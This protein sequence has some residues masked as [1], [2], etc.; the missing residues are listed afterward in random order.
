MNK[1][2]EIYPVSNTLVFALSDT[3]VLILTPLLSYAVTNGQRNSNGGYIKI[4]RGIEQGCYRSLSDLL[5]D[6]KLKPGVG[7]SYRQIDIRSYCD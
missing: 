1:G 2:Y 6:M 7:V 3:R 4:R 5:T